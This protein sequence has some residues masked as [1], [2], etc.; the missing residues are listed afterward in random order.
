ML[1]TKDILILED[2]HK[3]SNLLL[4]HL[5]TKFR[6]YQCYRIQQ[7]KIILRD[8]YIDLICLDLILPDGDGIEFLDYLCENFPDIKVIVLTRK[9]EIQDRI[10]CF[11]AGTDDY[12]PKPFFPEEL[13]MRIAKLLK[14]TDE[15]ASIITYKTFKLETNTRVLMY[16]GSK[17]ILSN[18]EYFI[19]DYLMTNPGIKTVRSISLFLTSKRGEKTSTK[20]VVVAIVRLRRKLERNIGMRVIKTRYSKG[21]EIGF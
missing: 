7:A 4:N 2:D 1:T 20:A 21:Y 3:I 8:R 5:K 19:M 16:K 18:T 9:S 13:E 10:K 17:I 11:K 12:L 14:V 6:I 15:K